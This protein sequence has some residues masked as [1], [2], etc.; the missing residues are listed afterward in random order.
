MSSQQLVQAWT[1]SESEWSGITRCISDAFGETVEPTSDELKRKLRPSERRVAVGDAQGAIGGCFAYDFSVSLG[2]GAR[3]QAG[4]LCGVGIT[5]AA[6][7]RGGLRA[8]MQHHLRQSIDLGDAASVLM[9]SES[10]IYQRYGYGIA[11][12]M[13]QWH[14]NT[15][16]FSLLDP[17]FNE[18]PRI[19]QVGSE[20][21]SAEQAAVE[22]IT[23][24]QT[25]SEQSPVEIKIVHDRSLAIPILESIHRKHCA[26]QAMEV[27]RDELWWRAMLEPV[28]PGWVSVGNSKFIA[29]SYNRE[30]LAD[31]YAIYSCKNSPDTHFSHGR[32]DSTVVL[33]EICTN[34]MAAEI[35]LFQYLV[36]LP[37]CRQLLWELG[38]VDPRI[39]HFMSDPRQLWQ[40]RRVDMMWLRPLNVEKLLTDRFYIGDGSVVIDYIDPWFPE[41]SGRWSLTVNA[42][43]SVLRASDSSRYVALGPSEFAAIYAGTIRV[44]ELASVGKITGDHEQIVA[45]DRL[46]IPERAPF[47]ATRF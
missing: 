41:L 15:L 19:K 26:V 22:Q 18:K 32:A 47:N 1:P 42:A 38:P 3:C 43:R 34:S 39:R 14:M 28:E 29:I 5:P 24:E 27:V 44:T 13:V 6:Q 17:D 35:A 40:Q 4:G 21:L 30:H 20:Q 46:L 37:W 7:G 45:L 9:A 2:G 12:E 10:G 33:T 23:G 36:N 8:M 16:E 31:G 25:S 11:T